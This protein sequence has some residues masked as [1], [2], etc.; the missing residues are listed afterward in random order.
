MNKTILLVAG[1]LVG[2]VQL[3]GALE[4]SA[5]KKALID[6]LL[7]Q[8]GQSATAMGKQFSDAFVQQM[9]VVLKNSNPNMDP[10]AYDIVEEEIIAVIDEEFVMKGTLL[11]IMYP[12]YDKH[13]TADELM[14]NPSRVDF[15]CLNMS[16][17]PTLCNPFVNPF[18]QSFY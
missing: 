6:E 8:T 15:R 4:I 14:S 7:V 3:A 9:T 11:E 1:L 13:F 18:S 12:I 5:E 2:S 17:N 16:A 10:I